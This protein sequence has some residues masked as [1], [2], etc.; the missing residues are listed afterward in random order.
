MPLLEASNIVKSYS[1]SGSEIPVLN[2]LS[3]SIDEGE[4]LVLIG[5]LGH[6]Y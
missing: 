6:M 3:I 5:Y 2:N 4:I 1:N